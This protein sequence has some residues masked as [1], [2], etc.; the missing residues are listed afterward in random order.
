MAFTELAEDIP[1]TQMVEER[2]WA[3]HAS[4]WNRYM[5]GIEHEGFANNPAWYTEEQYQASADLTRYLCDKYSIPKD[6][7]HIIGH[8]EKQNANW[9]AWMNTNGIGMDPS[10]NTH[11]DPGVFWNWTYF[12]SLIIGGPG[13]TNQP[14]SRVV[15]P[16]TSTSFTVTALGNATLKY[17]WRKNGANIANATTT[18]LSLSNVTSNDAASYTVVVTNSVSNAFVQRT[19]LAWYYWGLAG[20]VFALRMARE[21]EWAEKMRPRPLAPVA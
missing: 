9:V 12:M 14:L 5:L 13:I 18:I 11:T 2:F 21:A 3:W 4:C 6:R 10:C 1:A 8:N 16:G 19:T 17:Q 7:N 15:Q 20:L